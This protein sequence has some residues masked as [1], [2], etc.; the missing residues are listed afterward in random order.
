MTGRWPGWA[1][2]VD[3]VNIGTVERC[4]SSGY[5][6]LAGSTIRDGWRAGGQILETQ[7]R[8]EAHLIGRNLTLINPY[9]TRE[10][11]ERA[12]AVLALEINPGGG[13]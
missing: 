12:L 7:L 4:V 10:Q 3:G 13:A 9:L 11:T 5:D 1:L 2:V 8:A 6:A